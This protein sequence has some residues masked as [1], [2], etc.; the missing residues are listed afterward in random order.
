MCVALVCLAM[1]A[2][3]VKASDLPAISPLSSSS[4]YRGTTSYAEQLY[5]CGIE[6][7]R[8][9][10]QHSPDGLPW[11]SDPI[12]ICESPSHDVY[13]VASG[14]QPWRKYIGNG[15]ATSTLHC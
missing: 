9:A 1:V 14:L 6:M 3:P 4:K 7:K 15:P 2:E 10:L 8:L 13:I 5:F 11:H 12:C